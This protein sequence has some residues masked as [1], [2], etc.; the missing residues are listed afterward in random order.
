MR[1]RP[2]WTAIKIFSRETKGRRPPKTPLVHDEQKGRKRKENY[3]PMTLQIRIFYMQRSALQVD[4]ICRMALLRLVLSPAR[5]SQRTVFGAR[6]RVNFKSIKVGE[7]GKK[8]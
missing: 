3:L 8:K 7:K 4:T 2:K 1:E 6:K 5:P